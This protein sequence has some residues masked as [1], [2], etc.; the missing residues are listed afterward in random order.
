MHIRFHLSMRKKPVYVVASNSSGRLSAHAQL[1]CQFQR[2]CRLQAGSAARELQNKT[3]LI[4]TSQCVVCELNAFRPFMRGEAPQRRA[5]ARE[6]LDAAAS[7]RPPSQCQL[8]FPRHE[9]VH[10]VLVVRQTGARVG[11]TLQLNSS[12]TSRHLLASVQS[13]RTLMMPVQHSAYVHST[14]SCEAPEPL[15]NGELGASA[16]ALV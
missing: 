16:L 12:G 4:S 5:D 13:T 8:I 7:G 1:S 9:S 2:C 14:R 11:S 6:G 15:V 3:S 10:N